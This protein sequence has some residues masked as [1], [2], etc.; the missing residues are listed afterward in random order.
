MPL[1]KSRPTSWSDE[2]LG[3]L[4]DFVYS[5]S[6][7]GMEPYGTQD[8]R[9]QY[10]VER[11]FKRLSP[12]ASILD[13]GCGDGRLMRKLALIGLDVDGVE[14]SPYLVEKLTL[15]GLRVRHLPASRLGEIESRS[16]DC[17]ISSDVLEH[18]PSAEAAAAAIRDM[19][20][21]SRNLVLASVGMRPAT[22]Y[23]A[24]LG[25]EQIVPDLHMTLKKPAWWIA[26]FEKYC[27]VEETLSMRAQ[28]F[29][30]CAVRGE[31]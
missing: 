28:T 6:A 17:V 22:K 13:V 15:E 4:Y 29:I 30:F 2:T 11:A 23:P 24:A 5:R 9:D 7:P 8:T 12:G 19:A 31:E 18:L 26:E 1:P 14:V 25:I 10:F 16:R 20:R 3:D 27:R 21:I